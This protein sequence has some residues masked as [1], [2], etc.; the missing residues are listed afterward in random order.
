MNIF[1]HWERDAMKSDHRR[2]LDEAMRLRRSAI[3]DRLVFMLC[4]AIA[5]WAVFGGRS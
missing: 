5:M 1:E 2:Q 3:G 4:V